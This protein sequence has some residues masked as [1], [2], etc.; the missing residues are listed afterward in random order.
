M[1][2]MIYDGHIFW[3]ER[4]GPG[5]SSDTRILNKTSLDGTT[6]TALA[7]G[8]QFINGGREHADI[9]IYE[10]S[11]YWVT[12]VSGVFSINKVPINGGES[13]T[14]M[15]ASKHVKKLVGTETG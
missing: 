5:Q 15:S 8:Y 6:N 14:L 7:Q 1:N 13:S 2:L 12:S 9:A 10:D 11:V 4:W 3:I